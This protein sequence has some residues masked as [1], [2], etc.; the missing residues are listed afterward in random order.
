MLRKIFISFL[1]PVLINFLVGCYSSPTINSDDYV[2]TNPSMD[3]RTAGAKVVI[4]MKSGREYEGELLTVR[5][6]TMLICVQYGASEEELSDSTY[7]IDIIKNY[8][9]E[10]MEVEGE[11]KI[12]EGLGIGAGVGVA[13]GAAIGLASGDDPPPKRKG[14][15]TFSFSFTAEEK[16]LFLGC[17]LGAL[18][19][20]I[21]SIAGSINST[22]DKEVYNYNIPESYDFTQLNIFSRYEGNEPQYLKLIK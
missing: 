14:W 6:S 20:L 2:E 8:D 22:Y 19:A 4:N 7:Q 12:V 17:C 3:Q 1:L 9:I 5:D 18:G 21:G 10:L 11:S 15:L 13:V 16:A